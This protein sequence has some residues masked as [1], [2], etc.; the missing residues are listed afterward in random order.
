MKILKV[1][2]WGCWKKHP[3]V[4]LQGSVCGTQ[5][6]L[7][8]P[9]WHLGGSPAHLSEAG[10][11]HRRVALSPGPRLPG[12]SLLPADQGCA[13]ACPA[14]RAGRPAHPVSRPAC[15]ARVGRCGRAGS[16]SCW[17]TAGPRV[18]RQPV[19]LAGW[20]PLRSLLFPDSRETRPGR[21]RRR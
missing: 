4:R 9:A 3:K 15:G 20:A 1:R 17:F 18:G 5:M 12:L 19:G 11:R 2:G 21:A 16:E 8:R 7:P 10:A 13:G 6:G 14:L